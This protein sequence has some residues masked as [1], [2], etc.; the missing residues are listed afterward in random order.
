M[1]GIT[2]KNPYNIVM[3]TFFALLIAL[4]L[5]T[6]SDLGKV[7]RRYNLFGSY[8]RE[9]KALSNKIKIATPEAN[10]FL[11]IFIALI[12]C[13]II[14]VILKSF[15]FIY[16]FLQ[17]LALLYCLRPRLYSETDT[18]NIWSRANQ[19]LFSLLFWTTLLGMFGTLIY[20]LIDELNHHQYDNSNDSDWS[21]VKLPAQVSQNA[22]DWIP[23]RLL[24]LCFALIGNFSA[25][26]PLWLKHAFS[27]FNSYAL[28]KECGDTA[29]EATDNKTAKPLLK[30]ALIFWL[31]VTALS[32]MI[33]SH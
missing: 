29:M 20:R 3:I 19:Q 32:I 28:L 16:L 2:L 5:E 31:I 33:F 23:A 14:V 26:M 12:A 17:I 9:M 15:S 22:L 27:N 30:R 25:V 11:L 13:A 18:T 21:M 1:T 8:I 4:A 6:W 24:A 10:F 7:L